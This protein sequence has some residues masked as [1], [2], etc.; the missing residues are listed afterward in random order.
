MNGGFG[1]SSD[2]SLD[3][4]DVREM[5]WRISWLWVVFRRNQRASTSSIPDLIT[6]PMTK[7]LRRRIASTY[8]FSFITRQCTVLN[9][10]RGFSLNIW[11]YVRGLMTLYTF[12]SEAV[13][14]PYCLVHISEIHQKIQCRGNPQVKPARDAF[15]WTGTLI[16]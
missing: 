5:R 10:I 4:V 2:M 16:G 13:Q 15:C 7:C 12:I 14:Q 9:R 1:L 6:S 11:L 3:T 8:Y